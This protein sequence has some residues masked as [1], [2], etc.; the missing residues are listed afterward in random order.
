VRPGPRV[1]DGIEALAAA[2]HPDAGLPPR[3]AVASELDSR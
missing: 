2:L 3:P 1:V